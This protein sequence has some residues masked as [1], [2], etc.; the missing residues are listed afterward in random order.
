M[1]L[2]IICCVREI[3]YSLMVSIQY[4]DFETIIMIL[5]D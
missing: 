1:V 3:L 4:L 2:G 5:A